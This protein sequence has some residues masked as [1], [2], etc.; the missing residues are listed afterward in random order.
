MNKPVDTRWS[1]LGR[2]SVPRSYIAHRSMKNLGFLNW[3]AKRKLTEEQAANAFVQTTFETVEEGWPEVAAFLN[4]LEGFESSPN[5][6]P[7][8]YGRFLMIIVA[9]NL[10]FIPD[11]FDAGLD[12]MLIERI[13]AK[14]NRAFDLPRNEFGK[15]IQSY[16]GFMKQIN[17]PSKS[18]LRSMTRAVFYKYHLNQ[19]QADYFRDMNQPSPVLERELQEVMRHFLWDWDAFLGT[20]RVVESGAKLED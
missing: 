1:T 4:E 19:H 7:G 15:K 8:D 3:I 6:N 16:R 5:L 12:R 13:L 17:H 2:H 18:V 9:G 20:Y 14:F 10:Q 11:H